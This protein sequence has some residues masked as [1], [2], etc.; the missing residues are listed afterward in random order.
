MVGSQYPIRNPPAGT[1]GQYTTHVRRPTPGQTPTPHTYTRART[2]MHTHL[3]RLN[4]LQLATLELDNCQTSAVSGAT[5]AGF[6]A[7]GACLLLAAVVPA[8]FA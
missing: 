1:T 6:G 5:M 4:L 7:M 3:T 2:D 8:L